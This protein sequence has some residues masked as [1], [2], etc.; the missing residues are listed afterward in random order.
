MSFEGVIAVV[1]GT[2]S[3]RSS[4]R[5]S[6][7]AISL[8]LFPVLLLFLQLR[9]GFNHRLA[10]ASVALGHQVST[11]EGPLWDVSVHGRH[12]QASLSQEDGEG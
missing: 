1:M 6:V 11:C 5:Y 4:E 12:T 10:A 3:P 8:L 2:E 7:E 9:S